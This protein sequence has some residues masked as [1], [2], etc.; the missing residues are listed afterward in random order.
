MNM[1]GIELKL[2]KEHGFLVLYTRA[3]TKDTR[4]KVYLELVDAQL[5]VTGGIGRSTGETLR[6]LENGNLYYNGFV[7]TKVN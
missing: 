6:I 3:K 7:F 5:A 2:K 1:E 4:R